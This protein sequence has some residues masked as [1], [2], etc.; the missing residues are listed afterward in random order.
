MAVRR[1]RSWMNASTRRPRLWMLSGRDGFPASCP[2]L[3]GCF[4]L[5]PYLATAVARLK[6]ALVSADGLG[7]LAGQ[8]FRPAVAAAAWTGTPSGRVAY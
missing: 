7:V 3:K 6:E 1:G 2:V 5:P 8:G 4:R